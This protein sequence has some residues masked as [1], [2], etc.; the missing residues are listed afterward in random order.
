MLSVKYSQQSVLSRRILEFLSINFQTLLCWNVCLYILTLSI[1]FE[2]APCLSHFSRTQ[3][4]FTFPKCTLFINHYLQT[5]CFLSEILSI[6]KN[7][8][9]VKSILVAKCLFLMRWALRQCKFQAA[10]IHRRHH[11]S[12]KSLFIDC[13][14]HSNWQDE[15]WKQ[16]FKLM[17]E[18]SSIVSTATQC[19]INT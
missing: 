17:M 9:S 19:F 10:F 5:K 11:F 8:N 1:N 3:P 15:G 6:R 2:W 12:N 7:L 14:H 16:T 13:I 4:M 18:F